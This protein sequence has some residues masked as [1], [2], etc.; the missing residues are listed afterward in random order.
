MAQ[1]MR[2]DSATRSD[3]RVAVISPSSGSIRQRIIAPVTTPIPTVWEM[4][5]AANPARRARAG[6]TPVRR[7]RCQAWS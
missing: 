1:A 4:A 6:A 5:I 2:K 3:S 7:C